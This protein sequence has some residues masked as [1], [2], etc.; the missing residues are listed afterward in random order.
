MRESCLARRPEQRCPTGSP[1]RAAG[2]S[3]LS[4]GPADAGSARSHPHGAQRP[5]PRARPVVREF[6]QLERAA[7]AIARGARRGC[8]G[9]GQAQAAVVGNEIRIAP[10]LARAGK[11]RRTP[12]DRRRA[13]RARPRCSR[14]SASRRASARPRLRSRA[15]S[16]PC[17]CGDAVAAGQAGTCAAHRAPSLRG[18]RNERRSVSGRANGRHATGA[19]DGGGPGHAGAATYRSRLGRSPSFLGPPSESMG[20]ASR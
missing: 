17:G 1:H 16:R 5:H 10:V 6:E 20:A 2:R 12:E 15:V 13:G 7:E 18:R 4:C 14:R 8:T 19:E 9:A 11:R 3:R